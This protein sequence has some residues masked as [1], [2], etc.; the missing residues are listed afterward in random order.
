MQ[1][2]EKHRNR[3]GMHV[4]NRAFGNIGFQS[5]WVFG[6]HELEEHRNGDSLVDLSIIELD[7]EDSDDAGV[8]VRGGE[9]DP[10][11]LEMVP[12]VLLRCDRRFHRWSS[13]AKVYGDEG[14]A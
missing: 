7:V 3:I 1:G 5:T 12:R 9:E 6:S 2:Q 4:Q 13:S 8:T 14:E 11:P 10:R